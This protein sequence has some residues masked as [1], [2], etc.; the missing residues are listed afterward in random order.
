[1]KRNGNGHKHTSILEGL[2]IPGLALDDDAYAK[3][4]LRLDCYDDYILARK[5]DAGQPSPFYA[6][7]PLDAAAA[8]AGVTITTPTLPRNCLFWQRIGD[9]ER[10]AVYCEPR[11]WSVHVAL[12]GENDDPKRKRGKRR[13][14]Q[15]PMPGLVWVG[16]GVNYKLYA[17]KD[18]GQGSGIGGQFFPDDAAEL[19]NAPCPNVSGGICRGNVDF[20]AA[21]TETIWNALRLFFESDFN[22]HLSNGKSKAHPGNLLRAWDALAG[23]EDWPVEDLVSAGV[24]LGRVKG[25]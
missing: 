3:L 6:L 8:L 19:F 4:R 12:A 16:Q 5:Y 22:N 21:S 23:A 14:M 15:V 18:G 17:V 9:S 20:P 25:E 7:D 10:L 1:M 2:V 11:V 13:A 24:T